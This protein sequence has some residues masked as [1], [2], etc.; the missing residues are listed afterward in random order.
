MIFSNFIQVYKMCKQTFRC[1]DCATNVFDEYYMV[2]NH[3]WAGVT[4]FRAAHMLCVGCLESRLGRRLTVLDF[5]NAPVNM[6]FGEVSKRLQ[7]RLDR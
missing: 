6:G 3:I 5:T 1:T 7:D 4:M 2:H